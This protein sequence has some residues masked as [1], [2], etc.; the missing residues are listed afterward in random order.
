M[1][2]QTMGRHQRLYLYV[3]YVLGGAFA[4]N[5][6]LDTLNNAV[7][8]LDVPTSLVVTVVILLGWAGIEVVVRRRIPWKF[9][10]GPVVR[11]SKLGV[12]PRLG[13]LG[14]I[15][16]LWLPHALALVREKPT[17]SPTIGAIVTNVNVGLLPVQQPPEPTESD[18]SD[19]RIAN[20]A[21]NRC[22][23]VR[24][25][26]RLRPDG[27][28]VTQAQ[29][30]LAARSQVSV[31]HWTGFSTPSLVTGTSSL[32]H[33]G[34]QVG[35]CR[36]AQESARR[37]AENGCQ[38]YGSAIDK[39]RNVTLTMAD[40]ECDCRDLALSVPGQPTI[41]SWRCTVRTSYQCR[42]ETL[43]Q[44]TQESCAAPSATKER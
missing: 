20:T 22:E 14:V 38:L 41:P 43:S 9:D 12:G 8:L 27:A 29:N 30:I 19:W 35:A 5:Q 4:V 42:G 26:L 7:S 3:T 21:S 28:F 10:K 44:R 25:Y 40:G 11:V 34:S 37:N 17:P 23:G 36:S 33:R 16:V 32:D 15:G 31:P 6:V 18:R 1:T 13:I 24:S 39:Y 2:S